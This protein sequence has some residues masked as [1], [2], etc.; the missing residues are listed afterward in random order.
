MSH[1]ALDRALWFTGN[2]FLICIRRRRGPIAAEEFDTDR[3]SIAIELARVTPVLIG[4]K[5]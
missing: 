5:Y 4:C 2:N 1:D 3:D